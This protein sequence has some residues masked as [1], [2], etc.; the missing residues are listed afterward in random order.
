MKNFLMIVM[1]IG[2]YSNHC[3]AMDGQEDCKFLNEPIFDLGSLTKESIKKILTQ[4]GDE[5]WSIELNT[6]TIFKCTGESDELHCNISINLL[7]YLVEE[8]QKVSKRPFAK[9]AAELLNKI[10]EKMDNDSTNMFNRL[11]VGLRR[12]DLI[13]GYQAFGST[14]V[15]GSD[16][17]MDAGLLI[18]DIK[19]CVSGEKFDRCDETISWLKSLARKDKSRYS[20]KYY[21][22]ISKIEEINESRI[23]E[24]S[25]TIPKEDEITEPEVEEIYGL[26]GESSRDKKAMIGECQKLGW[27]PQSGPCLK[28][29][30]QLELVVKAMKFDGKKAF[31]DKLNRMANR[32]GMSLDMIDKIKEAK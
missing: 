13:R 15:Y 1:I 11:G 32:I 16:S 25:Q 8:N 14:D 18:M 24:F 4:C 28:T 21:E 2:A 6:D 9:D 19:G 31:A 20:P 29:K 26:L 27:H 30:K 12:S 22:L 7:Q 23:K 5:G 3:L 10:E 17:R